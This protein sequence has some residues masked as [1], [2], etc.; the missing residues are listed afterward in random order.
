ME[1]VTELQ[2]L[3][4]QLAAALERVDALLLAE[5]PSKIK[6]SFDVTAIDRTK[7]IEWVLEQSGEA[8]RP[9]E[10]WAELQRLGRNDPK[11]EVQVTTFDLWQRQRIGKVGRGQYIAD[12][13]LGTY[14]PTAAL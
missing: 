10:I 13:A 7:A 1:P 4:A 9:V 3:R 14:N 8:M 12:V 6:T 11:M 2:A 5:A